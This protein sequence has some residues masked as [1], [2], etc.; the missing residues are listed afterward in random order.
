MNDSRGVI[1]W[2]GACGKQ[3]GWAL[4]DPQLSLNTSSPD[5]TLCFQ[6]T[7]LIWLPCLYLWLCAPFLTYYLYHRSLKHALCDISKLNLAKTILC[8]LLCIVAAINLFKTVSE[9]ATSVNTPMALWISPGI[10][11]PTILLV[12]TFIHQEFRR[13]IHSSGVMFMFWFLQVICGAIM[14]RSNIM[15]INQK[16][17]VDDPFRLS[18]FIISYALI[19]AEFVLAFFA[20]LRALEPPRDRSKKVG[21]EKGTPDDKSAVQLLTAGEKARKEFEEVHAPCPEIAATFLVRITFTWLTSLIVLGWRRTLQFADLWL[22]RPQDMSSTLNARF[23][24][25][26]IKALTKSDR[27]VMHN[28]SAANHSSKPMLNGPKVEVRS[29][30]SK[31]RPSLWKMYAKLFGP[32]YFIGCLYKIMQDSV[33]FLQPTLLSA[34]ITFVE[35]EDAYRWKGFLIAGLLFIVTGIKSFMI[36]LQMNN[37][38]MIG[39]RVRTLLTAA[40]YRKSLRLSSS[41]RKKFTQG[42]IVNLMSVDAQKMQEVFQ[43]LHF[44]WSGPLTIIIALCYLWS[45]LGVATLAGV[46]CIFLVMPLNIVFAKM[47]RKL[48]SENMILKDSRLKLLNEILNGMKVLKLY[49]W[50]KSF[51][52]KIMCIRNQEVKKLRMAA[53]IDALAYCSWFLTPFLISL[54]TFGVYVSI[55]PDNVLDANK[56]FVSLSVVNIMLGPI[57]LMS[58]LIGQLIHAIVANNRIEDFLYSEELEGDS[59]TH[60][61]D[62]V[63]LVSIKDGT[64]SWGK[65]EEAV[66]ADLSLDIAPGS[67]VA[68]VGAVGSGKSSLISAILGELHNLSGEV[69]VHG[70]VAYVPQQAWIQNATLKDN[71]LFHCPQ[72]KE[73]YDKVIK[74]C[75]LLSD[76]NILPGG[77]ETEIG[78]K[79]I[80]V[81]G[82]QKQRISL[83]RAVYQ[84]SD[85]YLLDDPLSAVDS[86]V[87]KH[88]FTEVI[89]EQGLLKNKT[90]VFVTHGVTYLKQTDYIYVL[91]GDGG[92]RE[93]GKFEDLLSHDGAFAEFIRNYLL[94]EEV[95]EEEDLELLELKADILSRM[96]SM[97]EEKLNTPKKT[98]QPFKRLKSQISHLS[99]EST[100]SHISRQDSRSRGMHRAKSEEELEL[101]KK[102]ILEKDKK[103]ITEETTGQGDISTKVYLGYCKAAGGVFCASMVIAY[104][105]YV[106]S[107]VGANIWLSK[108]SE[109]EAAS[110]GTVN[111]DQSNFRIGIY[112]VFGV[113]QVLCM[114]VMSFSLA[115]GA[116]QASRRLHNRMVDSILR[117]PMSFFD[118]TPLGRI[119]NRLSKDIDVIDVNLPL[120]IRIFLAT[121]SSVLSTAII[122][123]YSTAIFLAALIPLGILYYFVQ[124]FYICTTRQLKRIESVSRSP[125]FSHFSESVV[126]ASSIRAYKLQEE[127]KNKSDNLIDQNNMAFYPNV[128]SARWLGFNLDLIG[129]FVVLFTSMFAVIAKGNTT[130][131][132]VGLSVSYAMRVTNILSYMVKMVCEVENCVVS[133]DRVREYGKLEEEAAW[134][135]PEEQPPKEWPQEGKVEFSNYSVRYRQGLDLVLKKINCSI[136][137][138]EKV[139]IVGRTGAGKSSLTLAMFRILEAAEGHITVDGVNISKIGLHD[140][141]SKI[142]IIPQDPVLFSGTLR[143]NLDPFDHHTDEDIWNSLDHSNLKEFVQSQSEKLMHECTEGGEN[144]SVGQR[145]LVCLARALLRKTKILV[146]DEATAA[147]DLETDDLIQYT[148]RNEFKEC[149]VI[150]I[151]HRLNTIMDYDRVIVLDKGE[152]REFDSP[153][154]LLKDER[155]IFYSMSKDAGL[156]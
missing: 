11:L 100:P 108:W 105:G 74:A 94:E 122:I 42:Q 123:T 139:G 54:A 148:I 29:P 93:E 22:M 67:L 32:Y 14:L 112:G 59:I 64:F 121:F 44:I 81:S 21:Y 41:G 5:L 35:T 118:T 28:S 48:Q 34:L 98:D 84:D 70:Q 13:G 149:T 129:N 16:G 73:K 76:L 46:G 72:D 66:L 47:S 92:I 145:Q 114:L 91:G 3:D 144:L 103:L 125:V 43:N 138:G 96:S 101:V 134:D 50:E 56:A 88:I 52:Q 86:H 24:K 146:L 116:M 6:N 55:S 150:T 78:D 69:V 60:D 58:I 8:A 147:V 57:L 124:R 95:D 25:F 71:I 107:M 17:Y 1:N 87:G 38:M 31:K 128:M 75:A 18:T 155:G 142:T 141:R 82:G 7:I 106:A 119:V 63:G 80:N 135:I 77:D 136:R 156:V 140:L 23:E 83:A 109:D 143:M 68:I 90:R 4:W 10:Y 126:G 15:Q 27:L 113:S 132:I 49:G 117:S 137:P 120:M 45:I 9:V 40:I 20:D 12:T 2:S 62:L 133:A 37:F 53:F 154:E 33:L 102:E 127:F 19:L 39:M 104:L 79:G 111:R 115:L 130:A 151:A 110:N 26:W 51:Q 85:I 97:S 30:N 89:G 152:I 61:P 131:G 65:D 153:S 36:G 99:R